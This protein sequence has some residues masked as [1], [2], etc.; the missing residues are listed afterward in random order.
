MSLAIEALWQISETHVRL[1][2]QVT[3]RDID[4]STALVVDRA[5]LGVEI[6]LCLEQVPQPISEK[7][8]WYSFAVKSLSKSGDWVVNCR[9]KISAIYQQFMGTGQP[10]QP[11]PVGGAQPQQTPAKQWYDALNWVG[12]HYG[13]VFQQLNQVK[14]HHGSHMAEGDVMVLKES[15]MMQDELRYIIH[16]STIDA[17]LQLIIIS[18]H[19]GKHKG[20]PWGVVP[21]QLDEITLRFPG[22]NVGV[23]GTTVAWTDGFQGRYFNTHAHLVGQSGQLLIDINSLRCVAYEAAVPAHALEKETKPCP[24]STLSWK[25]DIMRLR[26]LEYSLLKSKETTKVERLAIIIDLICH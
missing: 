12:F 24:F 5:D 22:D 10:S 26:P 6:Q 16:P 13:P 20:I 7:E 19:N 3:L 25:P 21:I 11:P 14:A 23:N 18:I 9:G 1:F 17:C 4:I 15:N 2:D 8:A